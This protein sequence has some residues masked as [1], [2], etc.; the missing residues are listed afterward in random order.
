MPVPDLFPVL[1]A[2]ISSA[3]LGFIWYHPRVFGGA[4][5]RLTG[6]TPEM[7]ER[8]KRRMHADEILALCTSI[9]A[10]FVLYSL[11]TKLGIYNVR[12]A[13]YLGFSVWAGFVVPVLSGTVL[14][15]QKPI[16]L[17][18]INAGYWLVSFVAMSVIL[19]Y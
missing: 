19:L 17:Y 15:E 16:S 2:G 12:G 7:V 1:F 9:L 4:W 13:V 5:M 8:G 6:L 3:F 14:W 18:I 10:A 11:E